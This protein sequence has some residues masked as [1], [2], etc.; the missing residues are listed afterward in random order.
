MKQKVFNCL[1]LLLFICV[2]QLNVAQSVFHEQ[3]YAQTD[4][5]LYL[6]GETIWFSAFHSDQSNHSPIP[7]QTLGYVELIKGNQAYVQKKILLSAGKGAG[8]IQ[9]P[10][11]L[12]SGNYQLKIYTN[13]MKNFGPESFFTKNIAIVQPSEK[14]LPELKVSMDKTIPAKDS[15]SIQLD[16]LPTKL[17]SRSKVTVKG[18]IPSA[19]KG[20]VLLARVYLDNEEQRNSDVHL[21]DTA[22]TIREENFKP[23]YLPEIGLQF[24]EARIKDR[25]SGIAPGDTAYLSIPGETPLMFTSVINPDGKAVF[26]LNKMVYGKTSMVVQ[27]IKAGKHFGNM[28]IMSPFFEEYS[29][30]PL[31]TSGV[32]QFDDLQKRMIAQQLLFRDDV[33]DTL[34]KAFL[35]PFD[36]LM[37]YGHPDFV[38][39]LD[40][41]T[42]FPTM[43]EVLREYV[44]EV[45]VQKRSKGYYF[46]SITRNRL[47]VPTVHRPV[48][49][50]DGVPIS[51][52]AAIKVNP[53]KI[54]RIDIIPKR[55]FMGTAFFDGIISIKT[56][57]GSL[58]ELELDAG[59]LPVD[60]EALQPPKDF[61]Q[62]TY[63]QLNQLESRKPDFRTTL[64]WIPFL[65]PNADGSFEFNF[66]TSDL[67][68][69]Y[70]VEVEGFDEKGR[71]GSGVLK[72]EVE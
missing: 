49:L 67:K 63:D 34:S 53:L 61:P 36:S 48:T 7:F 40:D 32:Q 2:S 12:A 15:F 10:L 20:T 29:S 54:E 9:L 42:R 35:L 8:Y 43:E 60:Y 24:I 41:F 66:Y 3:L 23:R 39:R 52:D 14:K 72:L 1:L 51:A 21:N 46:E 45:I 57:S 28:E 31:S 11:T 4:R 19:N 44:I 65:E 47:G 5:Q 55:Y 18:H 70:R 37:F 33:S 13:W 64:Y 22:N 56:Y 69:N 71:W 16:P 30:T 27:V 17:K 6:P 58:G 38:Y 62:V 25:S 59:V 26:R 50:L 68:G